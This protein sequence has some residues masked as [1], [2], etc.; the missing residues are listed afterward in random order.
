[1]GLAVAGVAL[2]DLEP[3]V[4]AV[5]LAGLEIVVVGVALVDPAPAVVAVPLADLEM[6]VMGVDLDLA[7][8]IEA[9]EEIKF[10]AVVDVA[11]N[12]LVEA[13][14]YMSATETF[15]EMVRV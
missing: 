2:V 8:E 6:V 15:K 7:V 9:V 4:V 13:V 10:Q 14:A 1:M 5:A 11:E 3:A 12:L